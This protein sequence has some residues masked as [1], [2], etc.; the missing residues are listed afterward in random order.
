M[1]R[2]AFFPK[3]SALPADIPILPL[4]GA[5]VMPGVQLPLNIFEPRYLNMVF[6]ALAADHL[7]GML[8]PTSETMADEVPAL[9]RIGCA[10]RIT[11]YSETSDGRVILVLTGVCRFQ[12]SSEIEGRKGYR[13][14]AVDWERFAAD[15][16]DDQETIADRDG[17]L[18]SLKSYCKLRGVEVPWDD[19]E[20][21]ADAELTN[22]LCAHLP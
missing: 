20:K 14:V 12:V 15:C 10:G 13:R 8:Q 17:F 21:M 3:F 22:L 1:T 7:L 19:I 6:D 9:H 4:A 18:T 11:S 5:I 16:H 2:N